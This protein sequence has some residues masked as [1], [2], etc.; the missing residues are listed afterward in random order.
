MKKWWFNTLAQYCTWGW[1]VR[2]WAEKQIQISKQNAL[3]QKLHEWKLQQM[4]LPHGWIQHDALGVIKLQIQQND[5][6][7]AVFGAHEDAFVYII[8]EVEVSR[9][10]VDGHLLHI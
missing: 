10:P 1:S 8:D 9:Q 5:A 2:V 4:D 7:G 3:N 6:S